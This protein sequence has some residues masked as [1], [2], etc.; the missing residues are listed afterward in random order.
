MNTPRRI[1]YLNLL[2]II[3]VA[4]AFSWLVIDK[5]VDTTFWIGMAIL[6]QTFLIEWK[7]S[8]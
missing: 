4:G 6:F 7:V 5:K 8:K 1:Y 3:C 2:V